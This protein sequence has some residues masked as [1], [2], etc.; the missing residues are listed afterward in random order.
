[1]GDIIRGRVWKFGDD[2]NTD[3]MLPAIALLLPEAQQR[4]YCFSANRPGWIDQVKPGDIIVGGKNYGTGSS[5]PAARVLREVGITCLLAESINGLFLRNSVNFG[6]SA[7]P[8]PGV[9]KAFE[10][11]DEAEVDMKQGTVTNRTKGTV[12]KGAPLPGMLL[13][14]IAAGGIIPKLKAQG[15]V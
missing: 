9:F 10:E 4:K 3:L 8:C 12:L 13:D 1:M 15:Y 7:M 11:G 5:R 14:I 2:I 6:L